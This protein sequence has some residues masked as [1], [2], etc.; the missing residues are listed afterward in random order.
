MLFYEMC[1]QMEK[2][3]FGERSDTK[4]ERRKLANIINHQNRDVSKTMRFDIVQTNECSII[5][6]LFIEDENRDNEKEKTEELLS[7][8]GVCAK[9]ID[10]REITL[11]SYMENIQEAGNNG[12]IDNVRFA[13][14]RVGEDVRFFQYENNIKEKIID[15]TITREEALKKARK[16][17]CIPELESE[18][19]RIF[20]GAATPAPEAHPVQY[21]VFSD[22]LD[23]RKKIRE[24]LV[25]SLFSAGRLKSRRICFVGADSIEDGE[26][27]SFDGDD[28][29]KIY[30]CQHGSTLIFTAP[31]IQ[32][33]GGIRRNNSAEVT[34]VCKSIWKYHQNTL[35]IVELRKTGKETFEDII[36]ALPDIRFVVLEETLIDARKAKK[37]LK[38]RASCDGIKNAKALLSA[39]DDEKNYYS[40]DLEKIY[41]KWFDERLCCEVYPQYKDAGKEKSAAVRSIK[42]SAYE[43]L[44]NL[45]G[46]GEA[47]KVIKSAIDYNKA[48]KIFRDNGIP[49][50]N[51]CRHMVFTGNPGSAKTTVARLFA[52]IMKDNKILPSGNL[53][54]VGRASIVD[55]FVGGTAPRVVN[56]FRN[57]RG[58][59]LFIDEA[60]SLYDGDRGLFGDEAVNAIVQE[61]ENRRDETIVIFAGYPDKMETFLDMN[62][63]LRSRISFHVHFDDYSE[64]ELWQI[65]NLF[66]SKSGM[67]LSAGVEEK[68]RPILREAKTHVN[69]GNG[70]FV[71]NLF[72]KARRNQASRIVENE[73]KSLERNLLTSLIPDDFESIEHYVQKDKTIGF[74]W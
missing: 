50:E 16:L 62:P 23:V 9:L 22:S 6:T 67:T 45:I 61:M 10:S 14:S 11:R 60:Y 47:K 42:G 68:V 26:D 64:D 54:E 72:E 63:G 49:V 59:V 41:W 38:N 5:L 51:M 34:K 19:E 2:P 21:V 44:E 40:E 36:E 20:K 46:L 28:V 18:I 57:A 71:R 48:Q 13:L 3:L 70:R 39:V 35:T 55:R 1:Y 58:K 4:S 15:E 17:S 69:F 74:T 12:F 65:L 7:S 37:V 31:S 24:L 30:N 33:T 56:L 53:I 52:Q 27:D 43:E 66:V 8:L 32:Y 25:A 29:E 73:G